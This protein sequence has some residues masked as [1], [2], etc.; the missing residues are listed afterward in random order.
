MSAQPNTVALISP[1]MRSLVST[2]QRAFS[3][4]TPRID[5]L[6]PDRD[7][8]AADHADA[9][10]TASTS[11]GTMIVPATTRGVTR[12][13]TGLTAIVE[14]ASIC[15]VMRIEPSSVAMPAPARAATTIDV[16]T[17][18][19]SRVSAMPSVAPTKP[20]VPNWRSAEVSCSAKTMPTNSPIMQTMS[21]D[22]TPMKS[23]ASTQHADAERPLEQPAQRRDEQHHVGA[24]L[25][26]D[27][28]RRRPQLLVDRD[29]LVPR[30]RRAGRP[31]R[32]VGA[33]HQPAGR[34]GHYQ[35]SPT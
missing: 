3:M 14:S 9:R 34:L 33:G 30:R 28:G 13:C 29:Q 19:S 4:N 26:D 31:L 18:A 27:A 25:L 5:V 22:C 7:A 2:I 12:Y 17:G 8:V 32:R 10:R 11:S 23:I 16:N 24:D 20:S 21:S 1:C 15:S 35:R 6:E